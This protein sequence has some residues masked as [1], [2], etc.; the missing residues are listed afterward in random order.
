MKI[1]GTRG[2]GKDRTIV[3]LRRL[4]A[5]PCA[6]DNTVILD[7]QNTPC[8][9]QSLACTQNSA[10]D[11]CSG[12]GSA[13]KGSGGGGSPALAAGRRSPAA[14]APSCSPPPRSRG[15]NP[16]RCPPGRSRGSTAGGCHDPTRRQSRRERAGG[17]AG[18]RR[19]ALEY[20]TYGIFGLGAIGGWNPAP[21]RRRPPRPPWRGCSGRL[22]PLGR[23][24]KPR[25]AARRPST[26]AAALLP[27]LGATRIEL[28][29]LAA[30][31][32]RCSAYSKP[33]RYEPGWS[34][35]QPSP[36]R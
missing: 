4:D 24:A 36:S 34:C 27:W 20:C 17:R 9:R 28:R 12:Q 31:V 8:K 18:S 13:T 5:S 25:P 32:R 33:E 1:S 3:R 6:K 16:R 15:N 35:A 14:C 21:G 19:K 11:N 30:I 29:F 22:G 7:H 26:A 10:R 23:A 2:N